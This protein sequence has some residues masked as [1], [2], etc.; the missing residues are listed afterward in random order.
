M[1]ASAPDFSEFNLSPRVSLSNL[2]P[3]DY[4]L[5]EQDQEKL[6]GDAVDDNELE[7]SLILERIS[8]KEAE[9]HKNLKRNAQFMAA[10][11]KLL[12]LNNDFID[13]KH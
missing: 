7:C 8:N 2:F 1:Q 5:I 10:I 13:Q 6:E 11:F 3:S 4:L 12:G 9:M